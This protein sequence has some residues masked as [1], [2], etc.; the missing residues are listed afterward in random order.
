[1]SDASSDAPRSPLALLGALAADEVQ[2]AP[3]LKHVEVY[4]MEGLLTL[5]WHGDPGARDVVVTCGGGMG[6]LL[7]PGRGLYHHLGEQLWHHAG[8]ATIR[9]G[10]R[11]PNHLPRCVHD[12]AATADLAT[13]S[14]GERFV[15]L[16]HSFG[17]AVA[18][19]AGIVLAEHC[20]GVMTYATQSAGCETA[21]QLRAPLALVHG[22]SDEILPADTSRVVA[23]LAGQGE[24]TIHEGEG[25][26]LSGVAEELLSSSAAWIRARF[27]SVA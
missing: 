13:R 11:T 19:Q 8:I 22:D 9:V 7:G 16:G 26:M 27:E 17:G 6:G 10:Y 4:T 15:V 3:T 18:V 14:G 25:H 2:I 23:A 5:L 12:V 1:V 21:A 20:A 24:I